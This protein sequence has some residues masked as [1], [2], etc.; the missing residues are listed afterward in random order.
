MTSATDEPDLRPAGGS[1]RT[2]RVPLWWRRFRLLPGPLR[3]SAYAATVLVLVLVATLVTGA[4]VVRRSFPQ[5]DGEVEVSGLAG[6]VDVVRDEHGVPQVYA[7][8]TEDLM[9]AQGYV[10]AQERFYEM[11][12]RRHATAGRLAE[13]FGPDA[14]ESD[15]VVRTMGWR[16]VAEA[17]LPLLDPD[18]RVALDAY[19]AG[20][21]AYLR[22]RAPSEVALEY[23][24]LNAGGLGYTP[25]PWSAVDSLAWLKAMAWD[26]RG[27]MSDEID[28][29]LTAAVVGRERTEQLWPAY[30]RREHAPIVGSGAVVDGVFDQDAEPGTTRF[31]TR[32]APFGGPGAAAARRSLAQVGAAVDRL[33]VWLGRGDGIGSNS[34]VVSGDRTDTGM[35]VL[36][37]DPHLGVSLPGVWMQ[38]GLHCRTVGPDCPYD[39][40]GFSFSGV[41]G[42]IIGH[43]ADIA[44][45]FTNLG[46]DVTDLY[47]ERVVGDRWQ[48]GRR[49]RPLASRTETIEVDG[50]DD[51]VVEV[52][53][54][55]HGPILS[56]VDDTLARVANDAD[57]PSRRAPAGTE[58]A[59]SL[60]WTALEP[61]PTA[62]AVLA[63][64]R[65]S[66]WTSFRAAV[67]D[68]AVP[69][70][71]I[72]YADR[73]G[74]IGY[75]APGRIPIRKSGNDGRWPSAGWRPENDWTGEDVPYDGLPSV[76][77]PDEGFVVTANQE[78][79]GPDYAYDLGSDFDR[80]YRSQRIRDLL[81]TQ[82]DG[83]GTVSV[84]DSLAVQRDTRN[85]VAPVLLPHLLAARL[86]PG[87]DDDGQRLLTRWDLSQ[88][89]EGEQSAAAA[90]FNVV[91]RDL[92]ALTFHD[93][94]PRDLWPDGGQRWMGAVTDL[95]EAPDDPWWDDTTTDDVVE[96]R[97]D[98][99]ARAMVD[100]RDDLTRLVGPDPGEW[101]WGALHELRLE[102]SS[103]GQSGIGL[104]E[105]TFNRGGWESGGGPSAVDAAAWDAA[106]GY[107]VTN[108]PSMRMVVSLADW[109]DARWVNLTG[110]SGHAFH[111]HAT[112]QTDLLVRGGSLPWPFTTAAVDAAADDRL[113]LVPAADG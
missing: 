27:N 58:L 96:R 103:L 92:L 40:A 80:G 72:V 94:L 45:G 37:N 67:A 69:S 84:D 98:I 102:S 8:T 52:R 54:T 95:L 74:H 113:R 112:D 99:V 59:V 4:V 107:E 14:V 49:L 66:D 97:D 64:N 47:V 10:H 55:A 89:A 29:T 19:A 5:T 56:D 36:A 61:A 15:V 106:E 101:T 1:Q 65:A 104:V 39:V 20:V 79:I 105:R 38:V 73:D 43:N 63:L 93:E 7:D 33:P 23:A 46:P 2:R 42:V 108:A 30:S 9:R 86:D 100:A 16:R 11:D 75:Q 22:D 87:Y 111:P 17:E 88:P 76:L 32:P 44:W 35:P 50:A 24:V 3:W 77:D 21:N 48:H 60:A 62:D 28:R 90:Y 85:P 26:L 68:F 110:V 83:D 78:V 70:Q 71:N 18:T 53:S 6:D 91:W 51:V 81:Q 41:P 34:W 31:P 57:V 13:L 12:V 82:L 109:D 25:E